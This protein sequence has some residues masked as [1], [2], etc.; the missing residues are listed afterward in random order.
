MTYE[1]GSPDDATVPRARSRGTIA[2]AVV[3]LLTLAGCA[4]AVT[5]NPNTSPDSE[6]KPATLSLDEAKADYF[7]TLD[8][9]LAQLDTDEIAELRPQDTTSGTLFE[10]GPPD[11]YYWPGGRSAILSDSAD[12]TAILSRIESAYGALDGWTVTRLTDRDREPIPVRLQQE[13]GIMVTVSV[14]ADGTEL[15][16]NGFS[17]CFTLLD[18]DPLERY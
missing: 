9:I 11:Q 4:G 3:L 10:C 15:D 17:A 6:P 2:T 1:T 14:F 8:D 13:G 5:M 12:P 16:L 7:R 18:Y